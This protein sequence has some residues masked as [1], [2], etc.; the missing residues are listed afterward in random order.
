MHNSMSHWSQE[1]DELHECANGLLVGVSIGHITFFIY[2]KKWCCCEGTM[3]SVEKV[4]F[5]LSVHLS[6]FIILYVCHSFVICLSF[7]VCFSKFTV[8]SVCFLSVCCFVSFFFCLSQLGMS[9]CLSF[10]P[11]FKSSVF[12]PASNVVT[13]LN[14]CYR[15]LYSW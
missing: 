13:R 5:N 6:F 15:W 7:D 10:C 11:M 3:S 12:P 9:F 8:L 2:V 1:L 14:W 4:V